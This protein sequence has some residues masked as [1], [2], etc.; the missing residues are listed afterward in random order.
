MDVCLAVFLWTPGHHFNHEIIVN[1]M[2]IPDYAHN[3][4]AQCKRAK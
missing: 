1:L 4:V 2:R 3:A